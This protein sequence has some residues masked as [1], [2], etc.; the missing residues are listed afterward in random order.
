MTALTRVDDTTL[1][2]FAAFLMARAAPDVRD[3]LATTDLRAL[4]LDRHGAEA[5]L[6]G[7]AGAPT[8]ALTL[9]RAPRHDGCVVVSAQILTAGGGLAAAEACLEA[10]LDREDP[11]APVARLYRITEQTHQPTPAAR[12]AARLAAPLLRLPL[13]RGAR[14]REVVAALWGGHQRVCAEGQP[15]GVQDRAHAEPS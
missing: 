13:G 2:A 6:Q 1:P 8:A 11:I 9:V 10:F 4:F 14:S 12:L 7:D 5:W 15:V 3:Y